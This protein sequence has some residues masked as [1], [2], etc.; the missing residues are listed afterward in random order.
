MG[1]DVKTP[2][3][4]LLRGPQ[5]AIYQESSYQCG[6]VIDDDKQIHW[7]EGKIDKSKIYDV[8]V[9]EENLIPC[10]PNHSSCW[11]TAQTLA[12]EQLLDFEKTTLEHAE[13]DLVVDYIYDYLKDNTNLN[14]YKY[15]AGKYHMD[16][17][18]ENVISFC[19]IFG[20]DS[21]RDY[22]SG[23]VNRVTGEKDFGMD[24]MLSP[25]CVIS[26]NAKWHS[27]DENEN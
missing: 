19:G 6:Y 16:Y 22:F 25:L 11:C 1:I 17:E 12:A 15:K 10:E 7:L 13:E 4:V 26:Q 23:Y 20:Q 21:P 9:F 18:D 24:R 27:F 3:M 8:Q 2:Q 5:L 14:F